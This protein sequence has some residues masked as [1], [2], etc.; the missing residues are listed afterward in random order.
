MCTNGMPSHTIGTNRRADK[1]GS[2]MFVQ[3]NAA[4][5]NSAPVKRVLKIKRAKQ[6]CIPPR[7]PDINPIEN[8]FNL[9]KK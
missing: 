4:N 7:S 1:N 5:Q 9:V 8:S 6:L 2:R 3:D